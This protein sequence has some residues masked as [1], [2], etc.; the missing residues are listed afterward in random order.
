MN[1]LINHNKK[2]LHLPKISNK[3]HALPVLFIVVSISPLA[4]IWV[5]F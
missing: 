3:I 4:N 5:G 2:F 1:K